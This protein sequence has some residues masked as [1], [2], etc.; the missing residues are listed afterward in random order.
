MISSCDILQRT[1][2]RGNWQKKKRKKIKIQKKTKSENGASEVKFEFNVNGFTEETDDHR[3][4]DATPTCEADAAR[5]KVNL[6]SIKRKVVR[7][8]GRRRPRER[9]PMKNSTL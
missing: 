7:Q 1:I 3:T 9:V 4:V 6:T 5:V 2:K 8:K